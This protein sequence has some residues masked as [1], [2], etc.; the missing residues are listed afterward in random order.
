MKHLSEKEII[1]LLLQAPDAKK[2]NSLSDHIASCPRCEIKMQQLQS[3]LCKSH[4]EKETPPDSLKNRIIATYR[5]R[6]YEKLADPLAPGP[7]RLSTRLAAAVI[8]LAITGAV[9][10]AYRISDHTLSQPLPLRF[11]L[12]RDPAGVDV[13]TSLTSGTISEGETITVKKKSVGALTA[14][15]IFDL[16]IGPESTLT[17]ATSRST[18][19]ASTFHVIAHHGSFLSR[20]NHKNATIHYSITTPHGHVNS[21]GTIFLVEVHDDRTEVTLGRGGINLS[22]RSTGTSMVG[23]PGN[24]YVLTDTLRETMAQAS[25]LS[26]I[27]NFDLAPL[28]EQGGIPAPLSPE[29]S[30]QGTI[31]QDRTSDDSRENG[32]MSQKRANETIRD[33]GRDHLRDSRSLQRREARGI[34]GRARDSREDRK[35]RH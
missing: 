30:G 31:L 15:G 2:G 35:R 23:R 20:I 26:G 1:T 33:H 24:R 32:R 6:G 13:K 14:K 21:L 5:S 12:E 29:E 18:K 3:I 19:G 22:C 8:I 16:K 28:P 25:V 10:L 7:L 34:E 27:N 17:I 4:T 9:F 11:T